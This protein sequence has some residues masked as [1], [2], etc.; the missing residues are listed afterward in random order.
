MP[1]IRLALILLSMVLAT[2]DALAQGFDKCMREADGVSSSMLLCGSH[3]ISAWD[4]RMNVAYQTLLART[5]SASRIRLRNEQRAWLRH[6]LGETR[7]LAT[8]TDNGSAAFLD[9][10]AFELGDLRQ[11]TLLLE[12]RVSRRQ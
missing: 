1:P 12:S 4:Q 3:E 11:R 5:N 10:Q 2:T 9:S 7:R 6:H 8:A